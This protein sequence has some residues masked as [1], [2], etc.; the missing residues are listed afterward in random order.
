MWFYKIS[1][2]DLVYYDK[3]PLFERFKPPYV[4]ES[5]IKSI[6]RGNISGLKY[7]VH[8]PFISPERNITCD[9]EGK[10]IYYEKM[11]FERIYPININKAYIIHFRYKSTE[12]FVN[13]IKRGYSNWFKNRLRKFVLSNINFYLDINRPTLEK[14]N[15]I[16]KGLNLNLSEFKR[17]K[18][19][20]FIFEFILF[21]YFLFFHNIY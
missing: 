7:W 12:E 3:R 8:S 9:N 11:N 1:D 14:I 15:F 5:F 19:K 16:E 17:K 21:F 13:K 10:R 20:W 4:K 18:L 2:N 6:I